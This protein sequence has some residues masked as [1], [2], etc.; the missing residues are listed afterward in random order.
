MAKPN[1][2]SEWL[3]MSPP[4]AKLWAMEHAA[5]MSDRRFWQRLRPKPISRISGDRQSETNS[6]N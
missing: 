6:P 5:G 3:L 4:I 1:K 2:E